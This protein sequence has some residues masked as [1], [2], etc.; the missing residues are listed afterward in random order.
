MIQYIFRSDY[1][2][3]STNNLEA[4]TELLKLW[5]TVTHRDI[6]DMVTFV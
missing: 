1:T 4:Q 3:I 6:I 2:L 5:L